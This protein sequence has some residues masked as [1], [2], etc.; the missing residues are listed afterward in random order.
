MTDVIAHMSGESSC[1][2]PSLSTHYSLD[3][4]SRLAVGCSCVGVPIAYAS[5]IGRTSL[6]NINLKLCFYRIN[7]L[8][9]WRRI[10]I[11]GSIRR[12]CEG[13]VW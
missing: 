7:N 10:R 11:S 9:N 8:F 4:V 2:Y 12:P 6:R 5:S 1:G 3:S 13:I